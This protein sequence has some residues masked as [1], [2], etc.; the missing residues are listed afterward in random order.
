MS[1]KDKSQ[2]KTDK[3]TVVKESKFIKFKRV[4]TPRVKKAIKAIRLI[5]NCSTKAYAYNKEQTDKIIQALVDEVSALNNKFT[6]NVSND[7]DF[8]L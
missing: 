3:P 2:K 1:N 6:G 4:C 8:S 5:G 7:S